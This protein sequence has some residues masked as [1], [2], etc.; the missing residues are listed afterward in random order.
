MLPILFFV[1][2]FFKIYGF[3]VRLS[4]ISKRNRRYVKEERHE[5]SIFEQ[6]ISDICR[7]FVILFQIFPTFY[8]LISIFQGKDYVGVEDDAA[9]VTVTTSCVRNAITSGQ[10]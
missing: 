1:I 4:S 9:T 8:L 2:F 7:P 10:T 5:I 3:H 6:I